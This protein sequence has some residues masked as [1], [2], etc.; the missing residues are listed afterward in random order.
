MPGLWIP[1]P[2]AP[3]PPPNGVGE[4]DLNELALMGEL[5]RMLLPFQVGRPP[6]GEGAREGGAGVGDGVVLERWDV[7]DGRRASADGGS[8]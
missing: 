2:P 8:G 1:G 6:D 7:S 4:D 5:V 3:S